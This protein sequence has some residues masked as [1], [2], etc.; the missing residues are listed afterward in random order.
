MDIGRF[1]ARGL[2][3]LLRDTAHDVLWLNSVYDREFTLPALL[4]ARGFGASSAPIILSPR[5]EFG[6]GALNV[7]A[8]KKQM[9]LRLARALRLWR[10]VTFHATSEAEASDMAAGTPPGAEI[11]VAP[12]L[13]LMLN[14]PPFEP[15]AGAL[16]L[17]FV[18]RIVPIKGLAFALEVLARV[19][20]PATFE[21]F[22]PPEDEATYNQ[23]RALAEKLPAPIA[24]QWRGAASNETIVNALAR[25][26][27]FL[28]PTGGEN[29][30]HAIFE[31]LSCGVPALI[32][33][34]T[35]WRGLTA[36]RAGFDLPLDAPERFV[37]ALEFYAALPDEAR[38]AWREGARACARAYVET[39]G[40]AEASAR[41]IHQAMR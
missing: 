22:G 20:R 8:T 10:G 38:A 3:R 14:P 31:A 11:V 7:K 5:G 29:F 15:P 2:N 23:C 40:A 24:V 16:R 13:R 18:G 28:L 32:S 4:A 33:D 34:R 21:I 12:N 41:L 39:S 27:L 1:G 37:D 9:F 6:A 35:P 36:R 26:D 30:G 25:S 17:I 19:R